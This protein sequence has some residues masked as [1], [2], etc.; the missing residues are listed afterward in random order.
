MKDEKIKDDV[1]M[2]D[3]FPVV[4][5]TK[6]GDEYAMVG[7]AGN[8]DMFY[9]LGEFLSVMNGK[10]GFYVSEIDSDS[11]PVATKLVMLE[12]LDDEEVD[13]EDMVE[14]RVVDDQNEN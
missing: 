7:L 6:T 3:D 8:V 2:H 9:R 14:D 1:L 10:A 13:K 12:P 4:A 11:K 5:I